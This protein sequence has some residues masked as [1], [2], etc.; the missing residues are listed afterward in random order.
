LQGDL[1]RLQASGLPQ[2]EGA[3]TRFLIENKSRHFLMRM[4]DR[5][6][7]L[8][9]MLTPDEETSPLMERILRLRSATERE[10]ESVGGARAT[11]TPS[12]PALHATSQVRRCEICERI[13][14]TFFEFLCHFQHAVV[15]DSQERARFVAEGGFCA[16]HFWLYA[17]LAASRDICVALSPLLMSLAARFRQRASHAPAPSNAEPACRMCTIQGDIESQVISRLAAQSIPVNSTPTSAVPIMCIPHLRM[18][19]GRLD[20]SRLI[21]SLLADH[22]RTIDRLAE[23]MRRYALKHDGLRRSLTSEE[24]LRA[25]DDALACVAGRRSIIR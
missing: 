20:D 3:L 9:E 5:A 13:N 21:A 17:S 8:I 24:E 6:G 11:S 10:R 15:T 14:G 1:D 2:L 22:S 12:A 18:I 23:D 25:A 4:V 7:S 19:S 16:R